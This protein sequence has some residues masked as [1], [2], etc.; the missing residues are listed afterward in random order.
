MFGVA[1]V[2]VFEGIVVE[3][4]DDELLFVFIVFANSKAR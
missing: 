4:D 3:V 1:M 2:E